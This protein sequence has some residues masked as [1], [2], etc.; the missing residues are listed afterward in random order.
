MKKVLLCGVVSFFTLF[1]FSFPAL[2]KSPALAGS[3]I[4]SDIFE[5]HSSAVV[6]ISS[7][8]KPKPLVRR[9][10]QQMPGMPFGGGGNSQQ[11]Q[12]FFQDF[13]QHFYGVPQ[14]SLPKKSLGTGFLI[15]A[16]GYI[17]TNNHVVEG[18]DEVTVSLNDDSKEYRA[19][20]IGTDPKTDIALIKIDGDKKFNYLEM[21]DSDAL[22]VGEWVVAIGNPFGLSNTVTVGVVSAKERVIGSGPYDN[23]IQ[24]DASINPGNSGGPL[25]NMQGKVIGINSAIYSQGASP[26]S[27]GIGFA[28]PVNLAKGVVEDLKKT[29]HVTRGYLGVSIQKITKALAESL[30]LSS[31]KGALVAEVMPDSPAKRAGLKRGDVIISFNRK[32]VHSSD[33]LPRLVASVNPG[34]KVPVVVLR[35]GAR[36][37]FYVT[38]TELDEQGVETASRNTSSSPAEDILGIEVMALDK[39]SARRYG[40]NPHEGV[41][42]TAVDRNGAAANAG[43]RGGDIILEI[44]Q[45]PVSAVSEYH[46]LL[47]RYKNARSLLLVIQRQGQVI[48]LPVPLK[49]EE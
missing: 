48:F 34:T 18:A 4:V 9:Q 13:F 15:D 6:N 14:R 1:L 12:D 44:N 27:I 11:F 16:E 37:S 39:E 24:T 5:K 2:A 45:E 10:F 20:I 21:G 32:Q 33:E 8:T 28:I 19:K 38:V 25:L 26:G 17:V 22:K 31:P 47:K 3:S 40:V 23:F 41:L 43:I 46:A 7:V 29:G 49:G 35:Q 36:K 42:V 30:H